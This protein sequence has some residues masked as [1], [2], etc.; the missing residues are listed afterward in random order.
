VV[1]QLR[2]PQRRVEEHA[3]GQSSVT[4]PGQRELTADTAAPDAIQADLEAGPGG[5]DHVRPAKDPPG[6]GERREGV[7]HTRRR[8]D[9]RPLAGDRVDLVGRETAAPDS[10]E[11]VFGHGLEKA[12]GL[13]RRVARLAR[14]PELGPADN[15]AAPRR[16]CADPRSR[17]AR[18]PASARGRPG[19]RLLEASHQLVAIP[20]VVRPDRR[21]QRLR[22]RRRPD[23][24]RVD[25]RPDLEPRQRRG[26]A[27]VFAVVQDGHDE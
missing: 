1:A 14:K 11:D 5:L 26:L 24:Q 15:D 25:A 10:S 12:P 9:H 2:I 6:L 3:V 8:S 19:S 21:E 16:H 20:A 7:D 17:P 4:I 13:W 18:G 27:E 23:A 22:S